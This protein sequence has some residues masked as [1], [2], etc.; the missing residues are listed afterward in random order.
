METATK[1][2][3]D[4]VIKGTGGSRD[5]GEPGDADG[6]WDQGNQGT[7]QPNNLCNF[8]T[9]QSVPCFFSCFLM[10]IPKVE[11]LESLLSQ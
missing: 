1:G 4:Q 2:P 6:C 8:D 7:S 11:R 10:L 5:K 9:N 3:R